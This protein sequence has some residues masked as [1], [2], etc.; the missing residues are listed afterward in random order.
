[1]IVD[2]RTMLALSLTS[3][4]FFAGAPATAQ[5]VDALYGR[6]RAEGA[7]HLYTGGVAANS[8]GTVRAF[9][10]RFPGIALN[11]TGDYSN[12]T[13]IK[14]DRQLADK[15]VDA[16][17]ASLQTVQDFVR[18]NRIGALQPFKPE[19]FESI[20]PEF[21][22]A[23]GAF[24]ATN[25]NPLSYAYNPTLVAAGDV[26][27]SALDFLKPQFRG[28]VVTCYPAD[29]DA[30]LFLFHTLSEK[31]G[32]SFVE[33]YMATEPTFVQGHAGVLQWI[34]DGRKA[35][36]FDCPAH[37]GIDMKNA[38][39]PLEVV[40]SANDPTP[41]FYNTVGILRAAPHP[42]AA[43]LF[44]SWIMSREQQINAQNVSARSD[45][46]PPT[47]MK[48]LSAYTP[49]LPYRE[50]LVDTRLVEDLRARFLAFTGPPVNKTVNA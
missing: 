39:R 12:V 29:D 17:I 18:W 9:N 33:R 4:L 10:A 13:D 35:L 46:P 25:V 8:A 36:T 31:Y 37:A 28:K 1:M 41:I 5:E 7:L 42:N 11:V 16:D 24:V 22:D 3:P 50:F 48:P 23:D 43:K 40:F 47:W 32:W 20:G 30:T 45:L 44:V 34:L 19:G 27:R 15:R 14:I 6:A 2:R 38:G 49:A 21:K 26:P